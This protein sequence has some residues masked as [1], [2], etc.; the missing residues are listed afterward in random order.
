ME[1]G[2][3]ELILMGLTVIHQQGGM[4]EFERAGIYPEYL[5]FNLPGTRQN[6]RVKIK[7]KPQYGVLKSKGVIVYEYSFDGQLCEYRSIDVNGNFSTWMEP[8]FMNFE[9]RD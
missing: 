7:E 1:E 5:L 4:R 3:E 2:D 8:E 9:L 6:W